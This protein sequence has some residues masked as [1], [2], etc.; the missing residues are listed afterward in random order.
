M[1]KDGSVAKETYDRF[2]SHQSDEIEDVVMLCIY[3]RIW[4]ILDDLFRSI[5]WAF[6]MNSL[7]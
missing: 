6:G 7:I 4:G 2:L 5:N 1:R 3:I